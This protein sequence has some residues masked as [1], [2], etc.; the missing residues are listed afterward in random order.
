MTQWRQQ[1][2]VLRIRPH[3]G[4]WNVSDLIMVQSSGGT[5]TR[6]L[7]SKNGT[8]H[9]TSPHHKGNSEWNWPTLFHVTSCMLVESE[10]PKELWTYAAQTAAVLRNQCFNNH[11]KKTRYFLLTGQWPNL[12]RMQTFG[13]EWLCPEI[14]KEETNLEIQERRICRIW[15]KISRAS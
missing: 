6:A 2:F 11:T 9:E 8:R 13:W 7:L 14:E 15:Q 3:I 5:I 1:R 12:S 4:R 10:L